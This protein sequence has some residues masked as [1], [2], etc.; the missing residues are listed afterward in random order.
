MT[1]PPKSARTVPCPSCGKPALY[2]PSNPWRPFCCERCKTVDLGAWA[3]E[4]Y[5]IPAKPPED[6]SEP[7]PGAP[8]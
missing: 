7:E 8:V 5:R 6:G 3:D 1:I 4:A 2:A